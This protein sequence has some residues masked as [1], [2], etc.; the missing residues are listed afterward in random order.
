MLYVPA[1]DWCGIFKKAEDARFV[2]GQTYM[3]GSYIADAP[4]KARGWLTAIDASTGK[5]IWRYESPKPMLAAVT[6]TSA[7]L[8]FG[9]ELTGDLIA[10]NARTG[11][12]LYRFNVG[13][14]MNGGVVTYAI[15][16]K[17]YVAVAT[18]SASGFWGA[19]PGSSTIVIF[20]L[21][22][23]KDSGR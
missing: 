15:N 17:Q 11:K 16:G 13:G 3:G 18:G 14:P 6:T 23:S 21:P 2:E 22:D 8:V 12:L 19:A 5:V 7:D 1:V 4:E 9:G 20:S 10:L